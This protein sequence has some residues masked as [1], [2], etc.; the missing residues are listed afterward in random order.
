MLGALGPG[1]GGGGG[2]LALFCR[3]APAPGRLHVLVF[4]SFA[5]PRLQAPV[6]TRGPRQGRPLLEER[7]GRPRP[8][9]RPRPGRALGSWCP[10][11]LERCGRFAIR[12]TQTG[13][14]SRTHRPSQAFLSA[15][16]GS[17]RGPT[18]SLQ[19]PI[20]LKAEP[21]CHLRAPSS[22]TLTHVLIP[23]AAS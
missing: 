4:P 21:A 17:L 23:N 7:A 19:T 22:P 14:F 20:H 11:G 15:P 13:D 6:N 1:C 18:L 10:R 9:P 2:V 16:G 12:G 3:G 8:R 5:S